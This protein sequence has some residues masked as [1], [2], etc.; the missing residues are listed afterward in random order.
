MYP[1]HLNTDHASQNGDT[2][3]V[4]IDWESKKSYGDCTK[5]NYTVHLGYPG[6]SF[7]KIK[8]M[9]RSLFCDIPSYILSDYEK[10][11]TH[12]ACISCFANT[13]FCFGHPM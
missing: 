1:L 3:D 11:D 6:N 2:S 13:T 12:L 8:G 10:I 5:K 7:A 4:F 9:Q